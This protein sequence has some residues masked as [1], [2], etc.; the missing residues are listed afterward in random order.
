[1][2]FIAFASLLALAACSEGGAPQKEAAKDTS[3]MELAAGQWETVS[4][5]T[6]MNQEDGGAPAMKAS[7]GTKTAGSVCVGEGEGK[8]PPA[9]LLSGIE[10]ASCDYENIYMSSGRINASMSCTR[11]D[12]K[13]KVMV[14]TE[15]T[16]TDKGFDLTSDTRTSLVTD[17][18]IHF[19]AKMTG[20]HAGVCT[21]A[22]GKA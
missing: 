20:R 4:E 11:P 16:Y 9:A 1:M 18:D 21:A 15:G 14:S 10:N 2:R 17:G 13:G 8:R 12:L 3:K 22:S 5:V 19:K 6:E 7:P